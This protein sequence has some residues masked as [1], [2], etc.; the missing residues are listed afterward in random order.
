M[1]ILLPFV[2]LF[3]I[4]AFVYMGMS[5]IRMTV[6][7]FWVWGPLAMVG[8]AYNNY[9]PSNNFEP[10]PVVTS[11]INFGVVTPIPKPQP[12]SHKTAIENPQ[13][14]VMYQP[15]PS[16][17]STSNDQLPV[18]SIP[19]ALALA[20]RLAGGQDG[21]QI[22][23]RCVGQ[24]T[25]KPDYVGQDGHLHSDRCP[26]TLSLSDANIVI[27]KAQQAMD[28]CSVPRTVLFIGEDGHVHSDYC[29][30]HHF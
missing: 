22:L 16:Q 14:P 26:T 4:V 28:G 17:Q 19:V 10:V 1:I 25:H 30:T 12:V 21:G 29:A 9:Q 24:H 18:V 5:I 15:K 7:S 23:P 11:Q 13:T 6:K 2:L 27:Q 3:L 8:L 20:G